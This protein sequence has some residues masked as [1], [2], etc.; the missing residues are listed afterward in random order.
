IQLGNEQDKRLELEKSLWPR[1]LYMIFHDQT[2]T[3]FDSLKPFAGMTVLLEYL[4][5]AEPKRAKESIAQIL[6]NAGWKVLLRENKELWP[7][8]FDGVVI[9][10]GNITEPFST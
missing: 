4:P 3:N 7:G 9:T 8:F 1:E 5:D 10:A 6:S 2:S